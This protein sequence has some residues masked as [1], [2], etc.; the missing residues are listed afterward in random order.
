MK[1]I[2]SAAAL[3]GLAAVM[4][5]SLAACGLTKSLDV[6]GK[7]SVAS[8]DAVLD[9]IPDQV[10]PDERNGGW[11]L[12]APD[13]GARFIWS[14]NYSKS[15]LHDVLLE[16]DAQPFIAAGL[17]PAKLPENYALYD[18]RLTVGVKLG[19]DDLTYDGTATPFASYAYIVELYRDRIGYH[20]ALDHY[21]VDVGGGNM[22]E[23]AKDLSTNDKDIVFMLNPEPLIKAGVDP[24]KVEGWVFAKV[25]V[26]VDGKP[27][28]ADKFLKPFNIK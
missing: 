27:A 9:A 10:T 20:T 12:A 23:W 3:T 1:N 21:G 25:S 14:E 22:F 7:G 8:F 13:N 17:D 11:S 28:E 4:V 6:V 19:N 15:P 26:E 5:F 2:F 16:L 24:A 18:G